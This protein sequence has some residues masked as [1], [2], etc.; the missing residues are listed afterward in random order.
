MIVYGVHAVLEAL[1][2]GQVRGIRVASASPRL[3][4]VEQVAADRGIRITRVSVE[5]LDRVARG[6]VHQGVAADVVARGPCTLEDVI[7]EAVPPALLLVLDGIEDPQNLGAILRAADAAGVDGV[8]RQT[9]RSAGLAAVAKTSAGAVSH[10]RL[11]SV[12]NIARSLTELQAA[13]IWTVGLA[14]DGDN[15]YS[16]FDLSL[17]T[18]LVL[19]SEGHGLRRLVRERC[20]RIASIPM[21]GR[22][23]SLN[24]AVA[25]GIGLFEAV[26]QRQA[27]RRS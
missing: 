18:A 7:A 2:S 9:R 23:N 22:V 8:V 14:A 27:G 16:D 12:V 11:A 13:G 15:I 25:A 6:A 1:R 10:V 4:E 3:A 19:G 17:P 26:R 20:D 21:L 24:V 5:A